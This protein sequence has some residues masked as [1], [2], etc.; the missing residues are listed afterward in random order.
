MAAIISEYD[1]WNNVLLTKF[2]NNNKKLPAGPR[3]QGA[4]ATWNS[5]EQ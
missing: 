3:I 4:W 1:F 5:S 2:V